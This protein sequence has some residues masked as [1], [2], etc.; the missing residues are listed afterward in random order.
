MI[1]MILDRT[2]CNGS[3][4]C[5]ES[6]G[7]TFSMYSSSRKHVQVGICSFQFLPQALC[8]VKPLSSAHFALANGYFTRGDLE[9]G[10]S[11]AREAP[12]WLLCESVK[13]QSFHFGRSTIQCFELV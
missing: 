8:P 12:L 5:T 7:W 11:H 3:S 2:A 6:T 1:G 4:S 13:L 9:D 10:L